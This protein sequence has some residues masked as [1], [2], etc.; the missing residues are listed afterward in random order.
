M[1]RAAAADDPVGMAQMAEEFRAVNEK[2]EDAETSLR[3]EIRTGLSSVKSRV[4]KVEEK[5]ESLGEKV[6]G[7]EKKVDSLAL[8]IQ[9][10]KKA[11]VND[12]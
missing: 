11:V 10:I 6:D 3:A 4:G 5:V 1:V 9:L 2:I 7:L 8:D 12:G